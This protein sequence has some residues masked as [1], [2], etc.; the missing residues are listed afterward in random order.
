MKRWDLSA[1]FESVEALDEALKVCA[2]ESVA[3]KESYAGRLSTLESSAF[4]KAIGEYENLSDAIGRIMSYAFLVFAEDT[5]KG[6]FYAKYELKCNEISEHLLFFE[7]E[8]GDLESLKRQEFIQAIPRYAYYLQKI[9]ENKKHTLSLPEERIMLKLDPVG[10]NAFS[11]LFDEHL[12]SLSFKFQGKELSEEEILALLHHPKRSK[13]EKAARSLTKGLA[14]HQGVLAYILNVVR[15]ENAILCDIRGYATPEESRHIDNQISQKS[16]DLMLEVVN[17]EMGIV[18]EFYDLKREILGY[19]EL[20][21]YDRYAPLGRSKEKIDFESAQKIVLQALGEFSPRFGE[22]AQRAFDEGW[23][24][25]HPRPRKR[26]GA[27]SHGTVP[28]AHPYV[29]LNH[30]DG[31][32]DIFTMAHELG[33]AIHQELSKGV[34][35]LN[36]D[37]PLTTAETAS[38]FAEML[39]F[40]KMKRSLKPKEK[41]TLYAGK[42]EDIFATLFRQSVFTNFERR[43]HG[44]KEEIKA[45]EF[46]HL[47]MEE[48]QKMFGKS[49]TLTQNYASWWSYIP[50]FVHTPFYCYAYSYGQLLVLALFGLYKR[51]L[52]QFEDRYEEFLSLGGSKRPAELVGIFG[53]DI[54][55]SEFWNIGIAEVRSLLEEFKETVRS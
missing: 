29:L 52:P 15:K 13:R 48:N 28:S 42:L 12:S 18:E 46:N 41:R 49:V 51:G 21:D 47:W 36:A 55:D 8:F 4:E 26:G 44:I 19:E 50:H 37:T 32:R 7:I 27:F 39:L 10:S 43:I 2:R 23:I 31:R 16:V 45:E 17:A 24:D 1:L 14:P 54:E 9:E 5:Q 3:F 53:F 6:D 40:D 35:C 11:R 34:G 20:Y 25:S 38:V 30:T 33:H 22:I